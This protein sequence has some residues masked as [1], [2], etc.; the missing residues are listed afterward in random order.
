MSVN[1]KVP[2][3]SLKDEFWVR[4]QNTDSDYVRLG[5]FVSYNQT[6]SCLIYILYSDQEFERFLGDNFPHWNSE[7][8]TLEFEFD[9]DPLRQVEG[10]VSSEARNLSQDD[11]QQTGYIETR[12]KRGKLV[13]YSLKDWTSSAYSQKGL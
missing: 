13:K 2:I 11:L 10:I 9:M 1:S 5:N 12:N 3:Y 4:R 6:T 8:T 7:M